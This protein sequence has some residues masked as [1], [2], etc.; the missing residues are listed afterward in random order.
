[1]HSS[2]LNAWELKK[3]L[4][5]SGLE[6][7]LKLAKRQY[8]ALTPAWKDAAKREVW[9]WLNPFD[10]K[11]Y[12]SGWFTE[13][14]LK[15]WIKGTGPVVKKKEEKKEEKKPDFDKRGFKF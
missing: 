14:E 7:E 3:A 1:L 13:D 6:K 11:T 9:F 8:Y 4:D 12:N 10:Q 15:E 2:D 5:S